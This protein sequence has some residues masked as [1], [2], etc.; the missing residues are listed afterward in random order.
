MSEPTE[1]SPAW[2][3][4]ASTAWLA[5]KR[6]I[7][8]GSYRYTCEHTFSQWRRCSRD[9]FWPK[10]LSKY[11]MAGGGAMCRQHWALAQNARANAAKAAPESPKYE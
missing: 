4:A 10:D 5:N 7:G 6:R 3:D 11:S 8:N 2:F 1:F 9:V